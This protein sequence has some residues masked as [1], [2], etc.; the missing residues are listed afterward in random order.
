MTEFENGQHCFVK[1]YKDK[2]EL[3]IDDG[4]NLKGLDLSTYMVS[5]GYTFIAGNERAVLC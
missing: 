4:F 2:T 5:N 3:I 1:W